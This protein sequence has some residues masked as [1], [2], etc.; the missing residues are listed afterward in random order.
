M[1]YQQKQNEKCGK[2][3]ANKTVL[4]QRQEKSEF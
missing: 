2:N 3:V 1:I 4:N